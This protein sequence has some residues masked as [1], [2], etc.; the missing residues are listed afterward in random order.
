MYIFLSLSLPRNSKILSNALFPAKLP[1]KERFFSQCPVEH[2]SYRRNCTLCDGPNATAL[3]IRKVCNGNG[4]NSNDN[5]NRTL[6]L[7]PLVS[8]LQF[9]NLNASQ[10]LQ[11]GV[12]PCVLHLQL[13][14]ALALTLPRSLS[15]SLCSSFSVCFAFRQWATCS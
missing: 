12:L 4:N 10:K 7:L 11:L 8:P 1:H 13:P 9:C 2:T 14:L 5:C 6:G 15:L 3:R